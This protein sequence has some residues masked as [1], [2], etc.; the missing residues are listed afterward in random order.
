MRVGHG[1]QIEAKNRIRRMLTHF[2]PDRD[3]FT[4]VRPVTDES[5]LQKLSETPSEKL[6]PEFREQ[7]E[8]LRMNIMTAARPK[9]MNGMGL[10]GS[11]LVNLSY[12]YTQ[13]INTGSVPSIQNAWSY[14][15]E[16]KCQAAL[17]DA[18]KSYE[19]AAKNL[20]AKVLPISVEE[21][22]DAHVELQKAAW[23]IFNENAMGADT[24]QF[25]GQ[26]EEK[27][28]DL[29]NNLKTENA[30]RGRQ[31]AQETL[32]KLYAPVDARVAEESHETFDEFEAE[33]KKVRQVYTD[34]VP[35]GP[36]KNEVL[37]AFMEAKLAE[38]GLRFG[39]RFQ[40]EMQREA[41]KAKA[42]VDE[43]Q[44][45]MQAVKTE[46][47]KA[48]GSVKLKLEY[49]EKYNE[50][51]KA[52]EKENKEEVARMRQSHEETLKNERA[53][54]EETLKMQVG[55]ISEKHAKA[56]ADVDRLKQ[57][58]LQFQKDQEMAAALQEQEKTFAQRTAAEAQ[59]REAETRKQLEAARKDAESEAKTLQDKFEA[60]RKSL[61]QRLADAGEASEKQSELAK[62]W[63]SK[64][65]ALGVQLTTEIRQLQAD[66]EAREREFAALEAKAT[67]LEQEGGAKAKAENEE[68]HARI[69]E[70][71]A[72]VDAAG[73][74]KT[75]VQNA[76][77]I[78]EEEKSRLDAS[79]GQLKKEL[80]TAEDK[81]KQLSSEVDVLT[82][83]LSE[84]S[85]NHASKDSQLETLKSQL[86]KIAGEKESIESTL[87]SK[88]SAAM[89][90]LDGLKSDSARKIEAL[91]ESSAEVAAKLAESEAECK[92]QQE[93][94]ETLALELEEAENR[95][96]EG[97]SRTE[98]EWAQK[99]K[100]LEEKFRRKTAELNA[101]GEQAQ[102]DM[103]RGFSQEKEVLDLRIR[104]LENQAQ[105]LTEEK[106]A[107]Q[108]EIDSAHDEYAEAMD[109]M[110]AEHKSSLDKLTAD[111]QAKYNAL[112]KKMLTE[113]AELTKKNEG[114]SSKNEVIEEQLRELKA[115]VKND[116]TEAEQRIKEERAEAGGRVKELEAELTSLKAKY[117]MLQADSKK[118]EEVSSARYA[119]LNNK[120][121]A[122]QEKVDAE[123][124][125]SAQKA[126]ASFKEMQAEIEEL[127]NEGKRLEN[128][129]IMSNKDRET[130][131]AL[132]KSHIAQLEKQLKDRENVLR[133]LEESKEAE[134]QDARS[135]LQTYRSEEEA[136][137]NREREETKKKYDELKAKSD[138][139]I[140]QLKDDLNA[141][142]TE[143]KVLN[144][145]IE[146]YKTSE[147]RA[148]ASLN[149]LKSR[150]NEEKEN[151]STQL[152]GM[153]DTLNIT[154]KE[155]ADEKSEHQM[156]KLRS[157][158]QEEWDRRELQQL[159]EEITEKKKMMESMISK[160]IYKRDMDNAK[161][162]QQG[163]VQELLREREAE[164][165]K[166]EQEH[167]KGEEELAK[168][169]AEVKKAQTE[170]VMTDSKQKEFDKLQ[171]ENV[172]IVKDI[173]G[174]RAE[175]DTLKKSVK[176]KEDEL[177]Q[178][179]QLLDST[180]DQ[181]KP[182]QSERDELK[183]E[184]DELDTKVMKLEMELKN[185]QQIEERKYQVE[186]MKLKT[187]NEELKRAE[188][189]KNT[190]EP[191]AQGGMTEGQ[192]EN[193]AAPALT[194]ALARV[195]ARRTTAQGGPPK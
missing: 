100:D 10:D 3:C 77:K 104:S 146:G 117:E 195:R 158:K 29:Y 34:E 145:R 176:G 32:E 80:R 75:A 103:R 155:L 20:E 15:C 167:R 52:R 22:E 156:T 101:A 44:R 190:I 126:E 102:Q 122:N 89:S 91:E 169:R 151:I 27:I 149:E 161:Q 65:A 21:L 82:R 61:A 66:A 150:Q 90:E 154:Q 182:V 107:K 118:A 53:K 13:S 165:S 73:A 160:E 93:D 12:A 105:D 110:E 131:T 120:F 188:K 159:K 106:E 16:S 135:K 5:L 112:E 64:H 178:T 78:T 54:A 31:R 162:T 18:I 41:A 137:M 173:E 187:E 108:K 186:I 183:R 193:I 175:I 184:R 179:R 33:R 163:Q 174:F 180:K 128:D 51:A 57:E 76:L 157:E 19:T 40:L 136:K 97:N 68:L 60:E 39:S 7:M 72:S 58:L 189:K 62:E 59:A 47:E 38:V 113:T 94:L 30:A 56:A 28:R 168:L 9:M 114:L 23:E 139:K 125:Q 115:Q 166:M 194:S 124:R 42:A 153:K 141:R 99:L 177:K 50:D 26:L 121:M 127:R 92:K 147:A 11:A 83:D 86:T 43:A 95:S 192:A 88:L 123:K 36:A 142:Q 109:E 49:A 87:Q 46:S 164:K 185:I 143:V 119:D 1:A 81:V 8:L 148:N 14:I 140:R 98:Q 48:L 116:K 35:N 172:R 129:K 2:F 171:Q 133:D 134:V 63:K 96:K 25:K 138:E 130:E 84:H 111:A 55:A 144:E 6:R 45:E 71:I 37:T 170:G 4:M 85:D 152:K 67:Q 191:K 70:L 132:H 79:C 69:E 17:G 181:W 24:D 74:E